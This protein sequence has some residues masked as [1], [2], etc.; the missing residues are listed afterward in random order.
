MKAPTIIHLATSLGFSAMGTGVSAAFLGL[1][2]MATGRWFF[3]PGAIAAVIGA[4][5]VLL[6]AMLLLTVWMIS[7]HL[8][9][10]DQESGA[11]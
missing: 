1:L 2:W 11:G 5:S 3:Y 9:T 6:G 7:P 10:G 4:G 8:D